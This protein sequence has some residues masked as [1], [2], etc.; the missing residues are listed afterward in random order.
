MIHLFQAHSPNDV[1]FQ[2]LTEL[3]T[4]GEER[5]HYRQPYKVREVFPVTISF[6]PHALLLSNCVRKYNPAFMV[7]ETVWNLVGDTDEWLAEY[8]QAYHTY[9]ENGNLKAGYGN[10]LYFDFGINQIDSIVANLKANKESLHGICE[11]KKPQD[12]GQKFCPCIIGF[13]FLIRNEKLHMISYLRSQDIMRGFP[14][15]ANL[16]C[17]IFFMVAQRFGIEVGSYTHHCNS[18]Q[19]FSRDY[20]EADQILQRGIPVTDSGFSYPIPS[21]DYDQVVTYRDAIRD[22]PMDYLAG[23]DDNKDVYWRDAVKTCYAYRLL[24]SDTARS[25]EIARSIEGYLKEQ[26]FCWGKTYFPNYFK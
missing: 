17:S 1:V 3:K 13:G 26:Y 11:I 23:L 22:L 6:D 9:F 5:Q 25:F 8:N 16:L 4:S 15:D 7:A 20:A 10:R 24:K 21:F 19:V 12:V 18:V 2:A 14:Y